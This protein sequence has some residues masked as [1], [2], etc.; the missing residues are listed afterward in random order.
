[1]YCTKA[2]M[3]KGLVARTTVKQLCNFSNL[4]VSDNLERELEVFKRKPSQI[5]FFLMTKYHKKVGCEV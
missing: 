3:H 5:F 1:M 2:V 4:N